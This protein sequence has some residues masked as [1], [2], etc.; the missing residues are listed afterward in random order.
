MNKAER[1][2]SFYFEFLNQL[3][4]NHIR[5]IHQEIT[6]EKEGTVWIPL[7]RK[8]PKSNRLRPPL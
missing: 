2:T 4:R 5:L 3:D 7:L 8:Y 6:N 1:K